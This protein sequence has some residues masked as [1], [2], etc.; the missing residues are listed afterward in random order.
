[1]K[2]PLTRRNPGQRVFLFATT[3]PTIATS[4]TITTTSLSITTMS[5]TMIS[6]ET[7]MGAPEGAPIL[8]TVAKE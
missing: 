6:L 2:G 7:R 8:F 5:K 1:M 4:Q 3:S